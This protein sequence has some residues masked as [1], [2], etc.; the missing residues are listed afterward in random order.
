MKTKKLWTQACAEQT[1]QGVYKRRI[2]AGSS[3]KS[4]FAI[5]LS[6]P[7]NAVLFSLR[8]P[9]A[10]AVENPRPNRGLEEALE[11]H[12]T[13]NAPQG[14]SN[15]SA[16]CIADSWQ[17]PY[18]AFYLCLGI[19]AT[20][21]RVNKLFQAHLIRYLIF[22]KLMLDVLRNLLLISP[23]CVNIVFPCPEVPISILVL[24]LGKLVFGFSSKG[25]V[26]WSNSLP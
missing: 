25:I 21:K 26:N 2:F 1:V 3:A 6:A 22:V 7:L 14:A 17:A 10:A 13:D 16:N 8:C 19:L 15:G 20:R 24:S 9:D 5:L 11:G 18:G 4:P 12:I 23:Y